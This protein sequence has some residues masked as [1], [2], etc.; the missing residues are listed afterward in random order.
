MPYFWTSTW[1]V[2]IC[3]IFTAPATIH[4]PAATSRTENPSQVTGLLPRSVMQLLRNEHIGL[5]P[6]VSPRYPAFAINDVK[7]RVQLHTVCACDGSCAAGI[8]EAPRGGSRVQERGPGDVEE[9]VERIEACGVF[10]V[11]IH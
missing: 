11:R 10:T 1:K 2:W 7:R 9:S 4:T 8:F 3:G 5:F 6:V